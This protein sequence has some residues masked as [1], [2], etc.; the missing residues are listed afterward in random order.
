MQEECITSDSHALMV[1]VGHPS[2]EL[3]RLKAW[4]EWRQSN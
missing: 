2:L 1:I 3:I 4:I